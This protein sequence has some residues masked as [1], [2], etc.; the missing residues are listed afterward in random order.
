MGEQAKSE[1]NEKEKAEEMEVW[2]ICSAAV[3]SEGAGG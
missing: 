1:E 3:C 2:F